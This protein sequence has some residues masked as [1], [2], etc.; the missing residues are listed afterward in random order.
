[1]ASA[2]TTLLETI[3]SGKAKGL[4]S[5]KEQR[6]GYY[7]QDFSTLNFEDTVKDALMAVMEKKIEE[8]MR[9]MAAGFFAQ[10]RNYQH[11]NWTIVGRAKRFGCFRQTGVAGTGAFDF[12]RADQPHQL[13]P[14]AD[15]RRSAQ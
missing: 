9:A 7:R 15:Y 6:V 11:K 4:K 13:P 10:C 5:P 3:A 12:G 1:M 14:F 8:D 2:R